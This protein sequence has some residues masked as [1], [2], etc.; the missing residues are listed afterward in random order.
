[1]NDVGFN[2]QTVWGVTTIELHP[3]RTRD[4]MAYASPLEAR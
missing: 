3:S 2:T 4:I 1:M